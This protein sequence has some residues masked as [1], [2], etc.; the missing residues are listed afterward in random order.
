MSWLRKKIIE[1]TE[2]FILDPSYEEAADM[3][4]VV[5]TFCG[6]HD[7][8]FE[9]VVKSADKKRKDSGGF[10]KGILLERVGGDK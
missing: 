2:E 5:R 6:L 8:D 10:K 3:L 4:E 1:E 9:T 7:L